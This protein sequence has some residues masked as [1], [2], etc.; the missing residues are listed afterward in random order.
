VVGPPHYHAKQIRLN[1]YLD[2]WGRLTTLVQTLT[3][4][5]KAVATQS[6]HDI[7]RKTQRPGEPLRVAVDRLHHWVRAGVI[8]PIGKKHPGAGARRR[9]PADTALRVALLQAAREAGLSSEQAADMLRMPEY[10]APLLDP[11]AEPP[12]KPLFVVLARS[13]GRAPPHVRM[14]TWDGL[15][16]FRTG[17]GEDF[18]TYRVVDVG[19]IRARL[20]AEP[21]GEDK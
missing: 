20:N 1:F 3:N 12:S 18:D 5:C 6:A 8:K 21:E 9:Y 16:K 10:L 15:A 13:D 4:R 2:K 14:D 11:A 19:Q 17:L 7:A